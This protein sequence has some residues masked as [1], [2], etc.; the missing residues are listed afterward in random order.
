MKTIKFITLS[1][2]TLLSTIAVALPVHADEVGKDKTPTVVTITDATDPTDPLEPEDPTN[3]VD[4]SQSHLVLNK[5]PT[6]Y[7]FTSS[8]SNKKY[9]ITSGT[10][11]E[12]NIEVFNDRTGRA[13]SVKAT[14]RDGKLT[15]GTDEFTVNN[16][17]INDKEIA[18]TGANGVVFD[19]NEKGGEVAGIKTKKVDQ[20]SIDFSDENGV[21]KPGDTLTG[22]IDY[23]LFNTVSPD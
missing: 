19:S 11:T 2:V 17:K 9:S 1:A 3:P 15:K 16:F 4:P 23:K 5:V 7:N 22:T 14:V 6:A 21:L 10:I 20:I 13:W 18:E 8:V 12:G